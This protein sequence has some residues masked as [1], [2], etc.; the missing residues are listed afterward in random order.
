MDENTEDA[1]RKKLFGTSIFY[2]C[3][4]SVFNAFTFEICLLV[5]NSRGFL[6]Y[7][8][9]LYSHRRYDQGVIGISFTIHGV[10]RISHTF[11][12]DE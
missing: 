5:A 10:L 1:N 4:E 2:L 3:A 6:K 11:G 9:L 8:D 12:K 7:F